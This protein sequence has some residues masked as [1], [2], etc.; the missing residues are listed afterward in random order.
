MQFSSFVS[1]TMPAGPAGGAFGGGPRPLGGGWPPRT[2]SS[3]SSNVGGAD[4][5][6]GP[7]PTNGEKTR[8]L[9]GG[10]VGLGETLVYQP[11]PASLS[12]ASRS[13]AAA[14]SGEGSDSVRFFAIGD[15]GNP[16]RRLKKVARVMSVRPLVWY[17]SLARFLFYA[18]HTIRCA[19]QE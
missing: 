4:G 9:G 1:T 12:P 5:S 11:P 3:W 13:S 10:A 14:A 7:A 19:H 15:W 18:V 16:S 6:V 8:D 2:N 17:S